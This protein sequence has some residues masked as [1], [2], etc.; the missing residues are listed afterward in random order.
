[1]TARRLGW[2]AYWGALVAWVAIGLL[3][4]TAVAK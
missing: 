2:L 4:G 3:I 1:M